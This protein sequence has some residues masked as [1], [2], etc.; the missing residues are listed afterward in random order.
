MKP[1]QQDELKCTF[2]DAERNHLL[3]G[4]EMSTRDKIQSFEDML[5]FAWKSGAITQLRESAAEYKSD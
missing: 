5:D 2:E 3:D 1:E 4:I